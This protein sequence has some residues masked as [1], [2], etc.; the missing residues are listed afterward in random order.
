MKIEKNIREYALQL[1]NLI[2]ILVSNCE[3]EV[4]KKLGNKFE[5]TIKE[6]FRKRAGRKRKN[7]TKT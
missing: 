1:E 3:C 5:E 6:I 7:E 2:V 4:E